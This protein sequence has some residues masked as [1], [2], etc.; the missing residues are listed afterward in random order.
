MAQ[1]NDA[2]AFHKGDR[3]VLATDMSEAYV[4]YARKALTGATD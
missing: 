2:A 4:P 1:G 3:W